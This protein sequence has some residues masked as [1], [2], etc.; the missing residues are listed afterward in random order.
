MTAINPDFEGLAELKSQTDYLLRLESDYETALK[1][2]SENKNDEALIILKQLESEEPGMWDVSHQ[3]E[4]IETSIQIANY[5]DE[6][7][8]A[9]QGERW[10]LVIIAYENA[11]TLDPKLDNP[12]MKEQLLDAYLKMIIGMLQNENASIED[13]ENA[14]RYHRRAVAMIPQNKAFASERDNLQEISSNL[15]EVKFIQTARAILEDKNQTTTSIAKAVSYLRE[16]AN[17]QPEN[18]ALMLDQKNA[19]NYQKAFRSFME[20]DWVS[21]ISSLNQVLEA[22]ANY[23]NGNVKILLYEAYYAQ[24]KL[25]NSISLY[26]D[27][28][29]NL[30]QAEILAWDDTDNL[31]KLFQVQVLLGDTIGKTGDYENAVSYY[32]YALDVIKFPQNLTKFPTLTSKYDKANNLLAAGNFEN[33]FAAFQEVLKGIDVVF[34]KSEIG[35]GDGVCLALFASEN[36]STVDVII[37]ANDLPNSMVVAFGRKLLV[38]KI[39]Y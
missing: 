38:P 9:Y 10:D 11:L 26:Q 1:L 34:S 28:R 23:A 6:G 33:S 3:I 31:M 37:G 2:I 12:V 39:N 25:L 4:L 21:A 24:G 30:E 5:L 18:N 14:E 8:A 20:M 7:N 15:L 13:I 29:L 32:K 27:A 36:L 22:D 19:E 16:A 35:I 17:L